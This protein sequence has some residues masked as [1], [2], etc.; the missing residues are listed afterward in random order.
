MNKTLRADIAAHA[1][2]E[3]PRE[4]CGLIVNIGG[5]L[6][7]VACKNIAASARENFILCP[8]DYAL[9]ARMGEICAVVHSH[10]DSRPEPS[11][12]DLVAC[13]ASGLPWHIYAYPLDQWGYCAPSGYEAPLLG[14]PFVHGVLDCYAAVRDCLKKDK[15]VL[16]PDFDRRDNWWKDG[17]NLY[18]ENFEKAGFRRIIDEPIKPYDCFLMQILSKVPNHAAV[19]LGGDIIYHHLYNRLSAREVYGGYYRKH[20]THILRHE[21]QET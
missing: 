8:K 15:G 3:H 2:A 14:R 18:V 16:I 7:Y 5:T 10:P 17:Q 6:R 20:T 12:A 4:A 11:Q 1:K 13:E 9:C 19:Y 21:S